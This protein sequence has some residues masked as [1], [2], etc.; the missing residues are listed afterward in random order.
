MQEILAHGRGR[1]RRVRRALLPVACAI[2]SA[3]PAGAQDTP[4]I[5]GWQP[6]D[7]QQA[8]SAPASPPLLDTITVDVPAPRERAGAQATVPTRGFR[9]AGVGEHP[10]HGIT[11]ASIQALVD[12]RFRALAGD[13]P[14]AALTFAQLQDVAAA[15]TRAYREA[16]FLVA[17]A[18]VPAQTIGEDGVVT[19]EALEGRLG[20]VLVEGN[21]RVRSSAIAAPA[22]RLEGR[23][24]HREEVDT[25]LLSMREL[26][27]V[28]TSVV[29]Q[30]GEAP[31]ETDMRVTATEEARPY[32]VSLATSNHG[33]PM[34]G[35]YRAQVGLAWRNALGLGD[36]FSASY[37]HGFSPEQSSAV[38][39]GMQV[40]HRPARLADPCP[41]PGRADGHRPGQSAC[42]LLHRAPG[43]RGVPG[44]RR[45]GPGRQPPRGCPPGSW[46]VGVRRP[47]PWR[48]GA[49]H[50]P[51]RRPGADLRSATPGA[52]LRDPALRASVPAGG[53][54]TGRESGDRRLRAAGLGTEAGVGRYPCFAAYGSV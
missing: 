2:L 6:G 51:A 1:A 34:T 54:G 45:P 29:L 14:E 32:S 26:P 16:G 36:V 31:G 37:A 17:T 28:D 9:V 5:A 42:V 30:P 23:S 25:A 47:G 15:V 24:L 44:A 53:A 8:L 35:R 41:R 13:A 48:R 10:R 39:V 4:S 46:R 3:A 18:Y 40:P 52:G 27:G 43:G 50:P 21:R 38:S 19:L 22:R 49:G 20:R 7:Q 11:P 33:S 12:A